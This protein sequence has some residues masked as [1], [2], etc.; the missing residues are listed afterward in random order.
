MDNF[1]CPTEYDPLEDLGS[2]VYVLNFFHGVYESPG[3]SAALSYLM[4]LDSGGVAK[5]SMA[6]TRRQNLPVDSILFSRWLKSIKDRLFFS[7]THV[8]FDD[9]QSKALAK[10]SDLRIFDCSLAGQGQVYMDE[11]IGS[12]TELKALVL[13][14]S[15]PFSLSSLTRLVSHMTHAGKTLKLYVQNVD[16]NQ[17]VL[18][19]LSTLPLSKLVVVYATQCDYR[20]LSEI[21]NAPSLRKLE[22]VDEDPV[23]DLTFTKINAL[24]NVLKN[25][26][27]LTK[28]DIAMQ[29]E[30]DEDLMKA[31][32]TNRSLRYL[33]VDCFA[34]IQTILRDLISNPRPKLRYLHLQN[35]GTLSEK[36]TQ[37]FNLSIVNCS[38]EPHVEVSEMMTKHR[39]NASI[40]SIVSFGPK[41]AP[42]VLGHGKNKDTD[43]RVFLATFGNLFAEDFPNPGLHRSKKQRIM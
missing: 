3:L 5:F 31:L 35:L 20:L 6:F 34:S 37:E 21:P 24:K 18:E 30:L 7:F 12:R 27:G 17:Q 2:Q 32:V 16:E 39:M 41:L 42:A 10:L 14:A 22:F 13:R 43:F 9:E 8:V 23:G 25:G 4:T 33:R 38:C 40:N 36:E 19:C 29:A 26:F 28:L 1:Y 11:M 15:C